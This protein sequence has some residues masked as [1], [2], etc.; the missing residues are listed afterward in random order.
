MA[1]SKSHVVR[2]PG[3]TAG[4]RDV[5]IP[6]AKDLATVPGT[7]VRQVDVSF[8]SRVDPL[9]SQNI[10]KGADRDWVWTVY[11]DDVAAYIKG[12][13]ERM[14]PFIDAALVSADIEPTGIPISGKDLTDD[15]RKFAR[16]LGFG[17]VGF[18]RFDRRY[19]Y[20]SKRN[21][22]KFTHTICLALEQ[23]YDQT[24]GLPSL[25][26]EYAHYGTYEFE[27]EMAENLA[28][29]IRD[30][31]YRAQIHSPRDPS[32]AVI[33]MFI[34][35]GLGQLGA[36]GQLLSPHFGS[37]A[38]LMMITTDAPVQYD[39]PVDYGIHNF[40][41]KCQ[42]CVNR[43][44]GRALVKERVWWR[45][46]EK[47]K[48]IYERCRPVMASYEGCGVCM[49]VCPVQ[50][51]GMPTVMNHYIETGEVLGKG[52]E[53]L[54][55]YSLHDKGHFGPGELPRFDRNFFEFP[56][57]RRENWLFD[58]FKERLA[59]EE[60][61]TSEELTEFAQKVKK[62]MKKSRITRDE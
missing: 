3:R 45:G 50:K 48:L 62:A 38:R 57:G 26:A 7:P 17:E 44:P 35:A 25:E 8:Y 1:K 55:G 12:H 36:N 21:W 39:A 46:V 23:D 9:E 27:S 47:N 20:E 16:E 33:P 60:T 4:E 29:F 2:R 10:E 11:K 34:E 59:L 6:V 5:E 42:V 52:S 14:K 31:G 13:D 24:Q 32:A 54:E 15:I 22:V 58:Q 51:F 56:H 30:R 18:T 37:R 53:E 40:C 61:P 43:C 28:I 49:K 41:Q 19:V